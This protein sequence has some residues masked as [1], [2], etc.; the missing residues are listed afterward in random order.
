MT[1]DRR[2]WLVIQFD[3]WR[4]RRFFIARE[5]E[6]VALLSGDEQHLRWSAPQQSW[7]VR[8]PE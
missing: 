6:G 8:I 3:E 7:M 1:I 2:R 5:A 4:G